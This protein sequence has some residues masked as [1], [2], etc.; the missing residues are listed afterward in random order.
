M[1]DIC[2]K[3]VKPVCMCPECQAEMQRLID[4][5]DCVEREVAGTIGWT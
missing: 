2:I 1:A 4:D 3:G 5:I